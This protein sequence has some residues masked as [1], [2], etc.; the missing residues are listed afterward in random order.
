MTSVMV[1]PE[2]RMIELT[3]V[4]V[5]VV[6][7]FTS[8]AL[9]SSARNVPALPKEWTASPCRTVESRISIEIFRSVVKHPFHVICCSVAR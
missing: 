4:A 9:S 6:V 1:S 7:R 8:T 5:A 2:I 3:S